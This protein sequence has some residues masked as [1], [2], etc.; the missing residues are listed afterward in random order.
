[1]LELRPASKVN[2]TPTEL[3]WKPKHFL[4]KILIGLKSP[5][6]ALPKSILQDKL[7]GVVELSSVTNDKLPWSSEILLV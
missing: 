1:M 2:N 3:P 5:S 4:S 7:E 6:P